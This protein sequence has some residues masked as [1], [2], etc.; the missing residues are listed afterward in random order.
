MTRNTKFR[1]A[2][3]LLGG[4]SEAI[5]DDVSSLHEVSEGAFFYQNDSSLELSSGELA[6]LLPA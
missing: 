3:D 1:K 4:T 2:V 5:F 6:G